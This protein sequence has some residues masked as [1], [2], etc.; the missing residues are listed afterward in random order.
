MADD[1]RAGQGMITLAEDPLFGIVRSLWRGLCAIY[2]Q[3]G[4]ALS[5]L[6]H[7]GLT[8]SDPDVLALYLRA[9]AVRDRAADMDRAVAEAGKQHDLPPWFVAR[10]QA[11]LRLESKTEVLTQEAAERLEALSAFRELP[12]VHA[13][14]VF[15]NLGFARDRMGQRDEAQAAYQRA[16]EINPKLQAASRK[17]DK[18]G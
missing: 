14:E 13:A 6:E 16:L 1:L 10:L 15:Y 7:D 3:N 17:L 18:P 9:L 5:Q 11:D 8:A 2:G 12:P 4:V